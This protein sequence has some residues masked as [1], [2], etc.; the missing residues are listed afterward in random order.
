MFSLP[1]SL[2][3]LLSKHLL[4]SLSRHVLL[5]L[6]RSRPLYLAAFLIFCLMLPGTAS[7][8]FGVT[9]H[10]GTL[11]DGA[12]Y[13]IEVPPNWNGTLFLYSHGFVS[14]GSPN[15]AQDVADPVTRSYMLSSGFALAGSSY[16][17]TG[18]AIHEALPDQI[19]VLDLFTQLVG[20]PK[21]TI[22]WGHSMGG[23]ITAGLI[24][25]YPSRFDAALPICGVLSGSVAMWNTALDFSFAF[26]TLLAPG[27]DL[28]VVNISDPVGNLLLAESALTL[29]QLTPQGRARLA[30]VAALMDSPG[31]YV[32]TSQEPAPTD[33]VS[34]EFNQF[35]W[36]QTID[37][38]F[39]FVERAELESRAGGNVSFNT[40]VDY[41]AQFANSIYHGEVVALYQETGLDLNADLEKLQNAPRISADPQALHYLENNIIFDGKISV[42]VLTVHTQ[43]DGLVPVQNESAYNSV[44]SAAGNSALLRQTFIHR[45]GHC[46][47]T[48]AET[49]AAVESL[50]NRLDT[51]AWGPVHPSSMDAAASDMGWLLNIFPTPLDPLPVAPA[52]FNF[53]PAPYLRPFDAL[54]PECQ[55]NPVCSAQFTTP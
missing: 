3:S 45:A 51:G 13:I 1:K 15:P 44:V 48:P 17:T 37:L 24:Q 9:T 20:A 35:L 55:S 14:R 33:F 18:W 41:I 38:P 5:L 2:V 7:A 12:T 54:S 6:D 26:K 39:A 30:L 28:Q 49:A 29:A 34:Q 32:P 27:V 8:Q 40:G 22:A 10:Q 21:R 4:L 23:I 43:G 50:V 19:A 16:A 47:I 42:P 25:R 31:W 36:A 46:V 53:T 52:Y 11:P